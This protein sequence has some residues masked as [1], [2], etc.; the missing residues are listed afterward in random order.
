MK[1]PWHNLLVWVFCKLAHRHRWSAPA[2]LLGAQ[3]AKCKRCGIT[4]WSG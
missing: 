3:I 2:N 4:G 1:A